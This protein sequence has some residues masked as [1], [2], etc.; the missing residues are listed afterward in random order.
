MLFEAT[1]ENDRRS[2]WKNQLF[3]VTPRNQQRHT[4]LQALSQYDS[5]DVHADL[6]A[7]VG[8]FPPDGSPAGTVEKRQGAEADTA[9]VC[10]GQVS[11]EEVARNSGFYFNMNRLNVSLTRARCKR[12]LLLSAAMLEPQSVPVDNPRAAQAFF[13]LQDFMRSVRDSPE[14][15][16]VVEIDSRNASWL[17]NLR[18]ASERRL[19]SGGESADGEDYDN[20]RRTRARTDLQM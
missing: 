14:C 11:P 12:I 20:G 13:Y 5:T 19:L 6:P 10:Y 16:S 9:I 4:M 17:R 2:F 1:P 7:A 15:G 8:F 18:V 3:L